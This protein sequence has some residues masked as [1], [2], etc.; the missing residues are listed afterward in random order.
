MALAEL[1]ALNKAG[2]KDSSYV[3]DT[4]PFAT[5]HWFQFKMTTTRL[6]LKIWRSP[7][8]SRLADNFTQLASG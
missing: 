2:L 4:A 8:C 5:S 1:E 3:E 7:V 6:S